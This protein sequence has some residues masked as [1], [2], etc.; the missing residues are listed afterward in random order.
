MITFADRIPS[1]GDIRTWKWTEN[2]E[3]VNV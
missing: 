3:Y 2:R 1:T